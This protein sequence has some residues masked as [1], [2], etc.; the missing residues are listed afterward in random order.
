MK[1]KINIDSS[2][3]EPEIVVH[4][5]QVDERLQSIVDSLSQL[6]N[7]SI[8]GFKDE[9][10]FMLQPEKLFRIYSLQGKIYADDINET[11]RLRLR[12]YEA[13]ERLAAYVWVRISHSE[14]INLKQVKCFDLNLS[15]TVGVEFINGAR[16]FVSRR[17]VSKIKTVL[18]I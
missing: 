1:I 17:Y 12:L 18:G 5:A 16:S 11:Y 6:S 4:A 14:I 13:E 15:G 10:V 2:Y 8:I 9:S 3:S 7:E